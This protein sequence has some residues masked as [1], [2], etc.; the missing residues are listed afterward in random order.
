MY[1]TSLQRSSSC[2]VLRKPIIW[3]WK[4]I[5]FSVSSQGASEQAPSERHCEGVHPGVPRPS[6]NRIRRGLL[7]RRSY[8]HRVRG[9]PKST[10][11]DV[12][13]TCQNWPSE[14]R[15]LPP[16]HPS[17][18]LSFN[19]CLIG[20]WGLRRVIWTGDIS[21][22]RISQHVCWK[23]LFDSPTFDLPWLLGCFPCDN[24]H[25]FEQRNSVS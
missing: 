23:P 21:A 19:H 9:N 3:E 15:D 13:D 24:L 22:P 20:F 12:N 16:T 5:Y 4:T 10:T 2:T 11:P 14:S 1:L 6:R 25:P 17:H 8:G 7:S 18:S